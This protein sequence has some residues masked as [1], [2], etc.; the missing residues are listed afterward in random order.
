MMMNQRWMM[1]LIFFRWD[2]DDIGVYSQQRDG[3]G[4]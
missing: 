1:I 4:V 2:T 3:H